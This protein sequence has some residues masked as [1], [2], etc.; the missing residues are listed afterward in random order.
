MRTEDA[1]NG[2]VHRHCRLKSLTDCF[3][4]RFGWL[5]DRASLEDQVANAAS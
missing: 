4:G 5:G 1:F 3:I 2:T